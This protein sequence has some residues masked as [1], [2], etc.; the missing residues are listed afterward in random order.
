MNLNQLRYL[1]S[2]AQTCSFKTAAKDCCVT[3]PTLSNGIA[4][5]EEEL[6]GKMFRRTTRHVELTPF[7]QFMLPL[8]QSVIEAKEEL[9]QSATAYFNPQNKILRIGLSPVI[10]H[11]HFS[12]CLRD[13]KEGGKWMDVFLKQCFMND[14][15]KRL[16]DETIDIVIQ[17]EQNQRTYGNTEFLY[18]EPLFYL[19]PQTDIAPTPI[20]DPISIEK[21]DNQ[22]LILTNGCG[23]SDVIF[24]L[25]D[26]HNITLNPYPGQALN[27]QVVNDWAGLG[28]AG[29]ILP[30]SHLLTSESLRPLISP[31]GP[32][33]IRYQ[34]VWNAS[35]V[36]APLVKESIDFIKDSLTDIL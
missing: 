24:D 13:L 19:P 18:Q 30:K 4:Q 9:E 15:E 29:G 2:L 20:S 7:G 35:N 6:G 32:L 28:L 8:A 12:N 16:F 31:A 17:P 10:S 11:P 14:M 23:L 3:Q 33:F 34:A 22:P 26:T 27:Y 25:F 1:L 21:L 5:L 36:N